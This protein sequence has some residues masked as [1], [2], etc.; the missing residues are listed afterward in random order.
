MNNPQTTSDKIKELFNELSEIYRKEYNVICA[1]TPYSTYV[2]GKYCTRWHFNCMPQSGEYIFKIRSDSRKNRSIV[3]LLL[4]S[5][6]KETMLFKKY[7]ELH[8][9]TEV[10]THEI[11][12]KKVRRFL[13][14]N[15]NVFK[16]I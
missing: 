4:F 3:S 16:E 12:P 13:L 5:Y 15:M 7:Y 6:D 10:L 2:G 11:I 1:V 8:D 14:F 9:L